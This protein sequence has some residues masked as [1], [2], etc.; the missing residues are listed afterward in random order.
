MQKSY[1]VSLDTYVLIINI[2]NVLLPS[3]EGFRIID[4]NLNLDAFLSI[5][6]K[7]Y[8][9]GNCLIEYDWINW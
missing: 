4:C 5:C 7:N 9:N 3:S 2:I 1:L 6:G 8:N